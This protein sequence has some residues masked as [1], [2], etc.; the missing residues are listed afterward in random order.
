MIRSGPWTGLVLVAPTQILVCG[1]MILVLAVVGPNGVD[2]VLDVEVATD[3]EHGV[4]GEAPHAVTDQ[5]QGLASRGEAPATRRS[6]GTVDPAA[7]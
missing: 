2:A 1:V 3:G 6:D 5:R 7:C 4:S